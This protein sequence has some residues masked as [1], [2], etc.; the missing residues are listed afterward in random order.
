MD[1]VNN[2]VLS[3][4]DV[5]DQRNSGGG[6]N[7]T[8]LPSNAVSPFL[9]ES[10]Q[11][12]VVE[13]RDLG[14]GVRNTNPTNPVD[15]STLPE[16]PNVVD[17]YLAVEFSCMTARVSA[18]NLEN[19]MGEG[20]ALLDANRLVGGSGIGLK[21]RISQDIVRRHGGLLIVKA[22]EAEDMD[23]CVQMY[24]PCV[25]R[26][27]GVI[28]LSS[29]LSNPVLPNSGTSNEHTNIDP[30]VGDGTTNEP[31]SQQPENPRWHTRVLRTL[32]PM[33]LTPSATMKRY[34]DARDVPS[35]GYHLSG[36]KM[37][38]SPSMIHPVTSRIARNANSS[39][40]MWINMDGPHQQPHPYSDRDALGSQD[41]GAG[42]VSGGWGSGR[43]A[44]DEYEYNARTSPGLTSPLSVKGLR[45][46][47]SRKDRVLDSNPNID[48]AECFTTEALL[49]LVQS[50]VEKEP[51][52]LEAGTKA[53]TLSFHSTI[54]QV[55]E[56]R[57]AG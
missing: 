42:V 20:A 34:T 3:T 49:V 33:A 36:I 26:L 14:E 12:T 23:L 48:R 51:R 28:N 25:Q 39:E 15:M 4:L 53:V 22:G 55:E 9:S 37:F 50:V 24:L 11:N 16:D 31:P 56:P 41:E 18:V 38:P 29:Q 6:G 54:H 47:G 43:G 7:A 5:R 32:G 40:S 45:R 17:G 13:Q 21:W 19:L 27:R 1:Y 52:T 8:A 46:A 2:I 35:S 30:T 44:I 10:D 57:E